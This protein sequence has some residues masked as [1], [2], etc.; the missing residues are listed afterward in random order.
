MSAKK[1][2]KPNSK[3]KGSAKKRRAQWRASMFCF[4]VLVLM[5]TSLPTFIVMM[6]G[7]LPTLTWFIVDMTPGRYAFRC[8]A[9]FNVAGVAPYLYKLWM[10]KTDLDAAVNIAGDPMAWLVFMAT[11]ACGWVTFMALPNM[12][13]MARKLEARRQINM[14][15][16][17][18]DDLKQ[19]WGPEVARNATTAPAPKEEE[20]P[21]SGE[22]SAA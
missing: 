20:D 3:P 8:I 12:I 9:G 18:Q 2:S 11:S 15:R 5:A 1:N 16:H 6:I 7:F 10:G 13:A 14:L 22:P 21:T 4:A 17:R 19:E